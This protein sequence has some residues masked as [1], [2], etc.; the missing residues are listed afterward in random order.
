MSCSSCGRPLENC[1]CWLRARVS[2]TI[3]IKAPSTP[4]LREHFMVRAKRTDSQ[5]RAARA[6]C[7]VWSSG[8]LL[9]VRLTRV[10]PR[11]L[12]G[13]NLQGALKAVRDG[14][15]LWLRVDDASPLVRWEYGQEKG[16]PSVRVEI[17]L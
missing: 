16:E 7:P 11:V 12:D 9:V 2:F 6:A 17:G 15:A 4:N 1:I 8:P 5:K 3:P 14:L 10:A 13:D